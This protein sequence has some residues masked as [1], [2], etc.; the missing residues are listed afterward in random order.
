MEQEG[1]MTE[2]I[3]RMAE[4]CDWAAR[5]GVKDREYWLNHR[6]QTLA[7]LQDNR[8][9]RYRETARLLR[10]LAAAPADMSVQA[11]RELHGN[12]K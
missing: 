11:F 3:E 12:P 8:N 9:Q 6:Q 1:A 5:E 7:D 10:A 2:H 4:A